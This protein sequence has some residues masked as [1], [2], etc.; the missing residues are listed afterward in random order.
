MH[1][2]E[3]CLFVTNVNAQSLAGQHW[4]SGIFRGMLVESW[5]V[6][7]DATE[8]TLNVRKGVKWNNGDDFTADDVARNITGWCDKSLEG[9]SMAGRMASLIDAET[10]QARE[11]AIT[12]VDNHTVKLTL[13]APD[14]TIIPGMADYPAAITHASHNAEDMLGTAVGTG[15]YMPEFLEVGVKSAVVKNPDHTC[16]GHDALEGGGSYLDRIEF[17]DYGTEPSAW[18]AAAEADEIDILW[19]TV[20]DFVDVMNS[21]GWVESAVSS[22][23]TIVIRPNQ[24]AEVDGKKPYADKRVRQALA[25]AVDNAVLLELGYAGR[26]PVA[27][28]HHAGPP[29]P[30]YDDSVGHLPFDPAKAKALMDEAGM[31]DYE[32]ELHSIDDDWRKNTTD[33]VAAQLRAAGRGNSLADVDARRVAA[34]KI[35]ALIVE[36]GVTI[37]PYFQSIYRHHNGKIVGGDMHIAFLPQVYKWG[38]KA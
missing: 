19:Q 7:D 4:R 31:G 26:G 23:S 6:N 18:V 22:G 17:I 25:M 9:N 33:V 34:G 20:G 3:P 32:H 1:L 29:H 30:E 5:D 16:W 15:A 37:Q 13:L 2:P 38:L 36:E 21:I 10:E 8:F 28:N 11:G 35:Q 24:L 14:N 12:V 27:N